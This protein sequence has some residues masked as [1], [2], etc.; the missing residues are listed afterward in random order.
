M[1]EEFQVLNTSDAKRNE[2]RSQRKQTTFS[3][4][5]KRRTNK[6]LFFEVPALCVLSTIHAWV[7]ERARQM[8]KKVFKCLLFL[9][10]VLLSAL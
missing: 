9:F 2:A 4:I 6:P 5:W 8:K 1:L 3:K 10:R 7:V